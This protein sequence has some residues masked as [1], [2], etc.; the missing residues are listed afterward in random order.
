M[1]RLKFAGAGKAQGAAEGRRAF[2]W[3]MGAGVSTALASGAALAGPTASPAE[4]Q[5]ALLLEEKAV[6][7]LYHRFEQ[8]MD[9]GQIAELLDHFAD[10]AEV[11]VNGGVFAGR[12][13]GIR[14]LY[15]SVFAAGKSG[16][17]MPA[18][19][20][21]EGDVA[22][23][24]QQVEVAADLQSA[25]ATFPYSL[26]MG[27]PMVADSSLLG[28]ARLHGEGVQTWWEG[29]A[30]ELRFSRDARDGSWKI[31]RLE[32]NTQVRANYRPGRSHASA[33]AAQPFFERYPQDPLGPDRLA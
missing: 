31:S 25:R 22:Q 2:F 13:R 24:T 9:T 32:Y 20:G 28:M 16:K 29:G 8:A 17:R 33:I 6:R 12:E 19:P 21:F 10:D 30:Y 18:A 3:K 7:E 11:L 1:K 14:R 23:I 27:R 15:S 5:L 4:R 26:Q